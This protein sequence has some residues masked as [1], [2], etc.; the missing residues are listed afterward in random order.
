MFALYGNNGV[1]PPIQSAAGILADAGWEVRVY[2]IRPQGGSKTIRVTERP[3]L[4]ARDMSSCPPGWRQKL[5]FLIFCLWVVV[6]TFVWRPRWVYLSDPFTTG[7]GYVLCRLG[8][9][10]VYHEHDGPAAGPVP[11][12][13]RLRGALA[14]RANLCV[15]PAAGRVTAFV[16]A[17]GRT[18]PTLCVN[19]CP[20]LVEVPPPGPPAGDRP[21]TLIY[22]GS[23]GEDRIPEAVVRAVAAIPGTRFVAVGYEAQ[24][25]ERYI[26]RLK[27]LAA[28]LGASDQVEFLPGRTRAAVW[29]LLTAADV[30]LSVRPLSV[31]DPN[32]VH[33]VGATNKAFDYFAAGL[34]LLVSELPEWMEAYVNEGLALACR[35]DDAGSV[36]AALRR[37][38]SDRQLTRRMG[39]AGRQRVLVEWNY[40]TQFEPVKRL[41]EGL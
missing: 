14:R 12:H 26:P 2:G 15:L 41:L 17:T 28:E 31:A 18:G 11:L 3:S 9:H 8:V 27:Q 32:F 23:I 7:V 29:P 20:R 1:V 35:P 4:T 40:E 39:E 25:P 24:E 13:L 21:L 16:A 19:N 22:S 6:T 34:P 36:A 33:M 38:T 5:H 10:V 37:F 30:G